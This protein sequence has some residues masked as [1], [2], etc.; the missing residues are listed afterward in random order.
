MDAIGTAHAVPGATRPAPR[1]LDA[2]ITAG[3]VVV[4]LL[5]LW[6]RIPQQEHSVVWAE[7]GHTFL[8]EAA[9]HG[10]WTLLLEPYAG[11]QHLLPRILTALILDLAPFASYALAIFVVC[12]TI[13]AG[14]AAATYWL[15]API[16]AWRPARI[17][18]AAVPVVLPLLGPEI[19]GNLA[20][21]HTYC[22][23]L[24]LWIVLWTP[25][26]WLGSGIAAQKTVS[27]SKKGWEVQ[28]AR[29]D[30]P[31]AM[32]VLKSRGLPRTSGQY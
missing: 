3:I 8:L 9:E 23:W 22:M 31:Y 28:V 18:L 6:L 11:Y 21:L 24:A 5:F 14:I 1:W 29:S 7:D 30:F 13:T 2:A 12:T 4:A 20:D 26:T 17:G 19:I 10:A 25:R 27:P 16:V 15:A 32:Q